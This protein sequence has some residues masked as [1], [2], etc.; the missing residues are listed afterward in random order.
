MVLHQVLDSRAAP[1]NQA[2]S[3]RGRVGGDEP[4]LGRHFRVRRDEQVGA[5]ARALD[6][7]EVAVVVLLIDEHVL[8]RRG[9]Q[10]VSP[11]LP[12]PHRL[13]GTRVQHGPV[14]VR[15]REPVVRVGHD[16]GKV[17]AAGDVAEPELVALRAGEVGRVRKET[18]VGTD[19]EGAQREE[20]GVACERVL[21]EQHDLG[22]AV[23]RPRR[24]AAVDRVL[25]TLDRT[26]EVVPATPAYRRRHVGLLDA[27]RDLL[28]DVFLQL[29]RVSQGLLRVLVLG[30]E[31]HDDLGI[32]PVA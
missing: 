31:I 18:L 21:V 19:C 28:E 4:H 12:R 26:A 29:L 1:G 20:P 23:R 8:L 13:V 9:A 2:G 6:V 5:G 24:P 22:L 14:V 16:V 10:L 15:P 17:G 3:I 25:Q 27:T 11:H 32:V 7:D 30:F